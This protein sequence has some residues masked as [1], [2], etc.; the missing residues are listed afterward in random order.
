MMDFRDVP[1]KGNSGHSGY[2]RD[3]D[4]WY[5]E[6]A[7]AVDW[8]LAR[9]RFVGN[10]WDPACG[11]GNIPK[12]CLIAGHD[13]IATDLVDRGYG[14]G[15]HDFL[16]THQMVD[17]VICNPPYRLGQEFV[18]QALKCAVRKVAMLLPLSFLES[19]R[20]KSLFETTPVNVVYVFSP[21]I[22]MP[23]GNV[24]TKATGGKKAYCWIVWDQSC[25]A[26][27]EPVMRWLP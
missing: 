6:P 27:H 26:D 9:E 2:E 1:Q 12:R 4:D 21:R 7:H 13:V 24:S 15:G 20:R 10:V 14:D 22:S 5:V 11:G 8:L 16:R 25:S 17:N 18:R 19:Q 3:A 23:P